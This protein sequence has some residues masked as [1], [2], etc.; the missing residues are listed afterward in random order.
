MSSDLDSLVAGKLPDELQLEFTKISSSDGTY[1]IYTG[2]GFQ[3]VFTEIQT[4]WDRP[5]K[6]GKIYRDSF[7]SGTLSLRITDTDNMSKQVS[8]YDPLH[9]EFIRETYGCETQRDVL[10]ND[11]YRNFHIP[12]KTYRDG[13]CTFDVTDINRVYPDD[14]KIKPHLNW[15]GSRCTEANIPH[16]GEVIH[17]SS[18]RLRQSNTWDCN[19][20]DPDSGGV[21]IYRIGRL[22]GDSYY[23]KGTRKN[24]N[25]DFRTTI[26]FNDPELD[27]LFNPGINKSKFLPSTAIVRLVQKIYKPF[28]EQFPKK[29]KDYDLRKQQHLQSQQDSS[30][31]DTPPDH[32]QTGDMNTDSMASLV[33]HSATDPGLE[34]SQSQ[35]TVTSPSLVDQ[36]ESDSGLDTYQSQPTVT[37]PSLVDHS[38]SEAEI[39]EVE[40][41]QPHSVQESSLLS[42]GSDTIVQG[43]SHIDHPG[44]SGMGDTTNTEPDNTIIDE[45]PN[46]T[47]TSPQS[48]PISSLLWQEPVISHSRTQ[49][50]PI[51]DRD[52]YKMIDSLV[53]L[54]Q[55]ELSA[56]D[57]QRLDS[58]RHHKKPE[59]IK[60]IHTITVELKRLRNFTE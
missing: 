23:P 54:C 1:N 39:N 47:S 18:I 55:T 16:V 40:T 21:S 51:N 17:E 13:C 38:E 10:G 28:R 9:L 60:A 43:D 30:D 59:L 6:F 44:V 3:D 46:V 45:D 4:Q 15:N 26:S 33:D 8:H 14:D 5:S 41:T 31:Y 32:A 27:L 29:K 22:L 53:T 56:V 48:N 57:P 20:T 50:A 58:T 12:V 19:A 42:T 36:I 35:P 2:G 34:T 25:Y 11:M 7:K 49:T 37:S 24:E 52:S